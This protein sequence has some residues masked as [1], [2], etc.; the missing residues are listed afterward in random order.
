MDM[1]ESKINT[2]SYMVQIFIRSH[3]QHYDFF[4][5]GVG[6]GGAQRYSFC[7]FRNSH[8]KLILQVHEGLKSIST[9]IFKFERTTTISF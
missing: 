9:G 3:V 4:V 2:T 5:C 6:W 1:E 8:K 7:I